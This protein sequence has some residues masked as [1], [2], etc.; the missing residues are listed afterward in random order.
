[1]HST[2]ELELASHE[3][4]INKPEKAS[5]WS[6]C[7]LMPNAR[8]KL[9]LFSTRAAPVHARHAPAKGLRGDLLH[10]L[11]EALIARAHGGVEGRHVGQHVAVGLHAHHG[12]V[13]QVRS[14]E[15]L[16]VSGSERMLRSWTVAVLALHVCMVFS[17]LFIPCWNAD[18]AR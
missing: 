5:R 11:R 9:V 3:L 17:Y 6:T 18:I 12:R 16:R 2:I 7:A 8:N 10:G 13:W 4:A 1:M 15:G 14:A